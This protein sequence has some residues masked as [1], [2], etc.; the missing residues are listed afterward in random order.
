MHA[1]ALIEG[2]EFDRG[3]D[4]AARARRFER[5][6][7][8]EGPARPHRKA[9]LRQPDAH[10]GKGQRSQLRKAIDAYLEA[11]EG[12]ARK[13]VWH[14]VNAV[15]LLELG[16]RKKVRHDRIADVPRI[17]RAIVKRMQQDFE[18]DKAGYWELA[19]AGEA[20]LALDQPDLAELW[21]RR[22][23][24]ADDVEPSRS[25]AAFASSRKYGD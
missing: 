25:R 2:G 12:D 23:V 21:Y 1:Q 16:E 11:Y 24:D 19:T 5:A 6:A 15:A 3:R 17:A 18:G 20:C 4:V 9:A 10:G 13:P 14:A 7:R 22:A 8:G